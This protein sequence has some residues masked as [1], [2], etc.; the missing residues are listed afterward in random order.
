[1]RTKIVFSTLIFCILSFSSCKKDDAVKLEL[2]TTSLSIKAG[3]DAQIQLSPNIDG[4]V[5]ESENPLIASVSSN[6]KV[7]GKIIGDVVINITNSSQ[8]FSA[9]CNVTVTPQYQ[10][11]REPYMNFG[12]SASQIKSYETRKIFS[13]TSDGNG[14]GYE[15]ENSR[16]AM[17]LYFLENSKYKTSYAMIPYSSSNADLLVD[18]LSERY[19]V[20]V[21]KSDIFFFSIDRKLAG[22]IDPYSYS[23]TY[24]YRVMYFEN[25]LASRSNSI[26]IDIIR[27]KVESVKA[28]FK[29][30]N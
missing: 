17:V 11:Y 15:G 25:P 19:T 21:D 13:E 29:T 1:M 20:I 2:L 14:I 7:S 16:I 4:C 30:N 9:K 10:M 6:G 22:S 24:Y 26:E 5:F 12:A 3:S 28:L 27:E 8:K 18:F 23:G